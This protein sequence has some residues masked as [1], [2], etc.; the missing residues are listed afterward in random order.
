M[1]NKDLD[2]KI[3]PVT[4]V[5]PIKKQRRPV[6]KRVSHRVVIECRGGL[7]LCNT[8]HLDVCPDKDPDIDP[9]DVISF[10]QVGGVVYR[11]IIRVNLRCQVLKYPDG[12]HFLHAEDIR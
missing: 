3:F 1:N 2:G 7:Y 10:H 9:A 12:F 11:R 6:M 5:H 4:C 8:V